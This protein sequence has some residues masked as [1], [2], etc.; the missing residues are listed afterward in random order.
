MEK[1]FAGH[2]LGGMVGL[3]VDVDGIAQRQTVAAVVSNSGEIIAGNSISN[4][5]EGNFIYKVFI[6]KQTTGM[7]SI[8]SDSN[9]YQVTGMSDDGSVVVGYYMDNSIGGSTPWSA[10]NGMQTLFE[11]LNDAGVDTGRY[12]GGQIYT[13]SADG[14]TLG[15]QV[16]DEDHDRRPFIAR[17]VADTVFVDGFE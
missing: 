12:N 1:R 8:H 15:G 9:D 6:W 16:E 13:V 11:W 3:G 17:V 2:S 7:V 10:T 14:N 4:L 5:V